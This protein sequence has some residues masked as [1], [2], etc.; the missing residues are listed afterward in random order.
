MR[1]NYSYKLAELKR[2]IKL[3]KQMDCYNNISNTNILLLIRY[4]SN[5]IKIIY[6][7]LSILEIENYELKKIMSKGK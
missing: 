2:K 1:K 6:N 7:Q 4:Q 5:I 3:I